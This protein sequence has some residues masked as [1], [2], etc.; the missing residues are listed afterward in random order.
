MAEGLSMNVTA[1][2]VE[3]EEQLAGLKGLACDSAQGF[4]FAKPLPRDEARAV[5][6]KHAIP[7][8]QSEPVR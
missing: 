3:T 4:Y 1:E 6:L 8:V 7:A 2:G 5:L